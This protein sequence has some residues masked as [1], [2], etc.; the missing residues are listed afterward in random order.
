MRF[1]QWVL[2]VFGVALIVVCASCAALAADR[3]PTFRFLERPE[4]GTLTLFEAERPVLAYNFADR[5]KPGLPA[6]R[7]RSC[8]IHPIYG[9]DGEVLSEDFPPGGHFHHRGLCWAWPQVKVDG[10]LTD[11]WDLRGIRARFRKWIER[12]SDGQVAN[13]AAEDDWV[14]DEQKVVATEVVRIRVQKATDVG[15]AI[16][17]EW[18][19]EAKGSPIEIAGRKKA[20]YGGLMLR[21]PALQHTAITTDQGPQK[22]DANLRPCAWADLSSRFGKDDKL[23]GAAIFLHASHPAPVGW[24]LR[25][26]GFLNPAWPGM[27]SVTL[28]PGKPIVLRYRLWIHRGDAVAGAVGQAF[29]KYRSET[30]NSH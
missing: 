2:A 16:D 5:L 8:Y 23:S 1:D 28:E 27:T 22:T 17:F 11:P 13:L 19:V 25:Y 6:D 21:F 26:Y 15:R 20:G 18:R 4:T 7:K 30:S 3:E 24:T 14:L 10:R 9:L 12:Q 29:E